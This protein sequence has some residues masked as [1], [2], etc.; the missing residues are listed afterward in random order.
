MSSNREEV[1]SFKA[2]V[3]QIDAVCD[4]LNLDDAYRLRLE[5]CE[6]ELIVNFPV[7]MDDGT[8]KVF[9]GFRVQHNDTRGPAKGGIRYH[10]DVTLD[11]TR[12]LAVWM[13]LKAAVV[14]IPYGGARGVVACDPKVLSQNELEK[15]TRRYASEI[16]PD[17]SGKGYSGS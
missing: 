1:N 8:V 10:P 3:G 14:N 15:L 17:R 7:K 13:T 16:S 2:A 5:K 6:R 12:A 9:T 11:E 4:R